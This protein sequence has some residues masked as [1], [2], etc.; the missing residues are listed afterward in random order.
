MNHHIPRVGAA[1]LFI[2]FVA[3][4]V[5]FLVLNNSFGGPQVR[6]SSPYTFTAKFDDSQGLLKKSFVLIRG[7]EVGFIES[8]TP[9]GDGTTVKMSVQKRY[10]PIFRDATVRT[11]NRT[12]IGEAYVLLDPGQAAAGPLEAGAALPDRQVK[13]NIEFDEALAALDSQALHDL[14]ATNITIAES[15]TSPEAGRQGNAAVG[16]FTGTIDELR[17]LTQTLRG[18]EQFI[19]RLVDDSGSVLEQ[20]GSREAT[21]R[22][23]V[24]DGETT[25]AAIGGQDAAVRSALAEAPQLLDA[26]RTTLQNGDGFLRAAR[27]L[28][29]D[30]R[31]AA[32]LLTPALN[33]LGPTAQSATR[34]VNRLPALN[35]AAVPA[36]KAARPVV[37]RLAPFIEQLEP[38]LRN[39]VPTITYN[40]DRANDFSAFLANI[41]EFLN[42]GDSRGVYFRYNPFYAPAITEGLKEGQGTLFEQNPYPSPNDGNDPQ[43]F[44]GDYPR[45]TPAKAPSPPRSK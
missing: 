3:T 16:E 17:R 30:V 31:R 15:A 20:I 32:P 22:S 13:P 44:I 2:A 24:A 28:V 43:R 42:H 23:L 39:L 8:I 10:A 12:L 41:S 5:L 45:L 29:A 35:S 26:A 6:L 11:G 34:V 14:R 40:A 9:E 25:L 21:I 19:S 4:T 27:P 36:L 1:N 38:T 37:D 7:V 33:D 18:Q